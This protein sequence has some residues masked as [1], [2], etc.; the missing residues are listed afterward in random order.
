[1]AIGLDCAGRTNTHDCLPW[2]SMSWTLNRWWRLQVAKR[3]LLIDSSERSSKRRDWRHAKMT[4]MKV[5]RE[6][7]GGGRKERDR[8][9]QPATAGLYG[10]E[11]TTQAE[12]LV[13]RL[14]WWRLDNVRREDIKSML[15][16]DSQSRCG[17][18]LL[19]SQSRR[20]RQKL[21]FSS[22]FASNSR[23]TFRRCCSIDRQRR[24]H[25]RRLWS[26]R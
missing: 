22:Y 26:L 6:R 17:W 15:A 25:F 20:K 11:V 9:G 23:P 16:L 18:H 12:K 13:R 19:D 21:I 5:D 24:H 1:M 8:A 7:G 10:V 14:L 3:S 4:E 2:D